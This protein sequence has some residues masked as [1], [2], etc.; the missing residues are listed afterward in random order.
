MPTI[1]LVDEGTEIQVVDKTQPLAKHDY[2]CAWSD[3]NKGEPHVIKQG[4]RYVRV[5]YKLKGKF[6]SDHI[7]LDC[8]CGPQS[9]GEATGS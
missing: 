8:W 4:Q 6:E 9:N 1:K 5:V 2:A 3:P 7:C